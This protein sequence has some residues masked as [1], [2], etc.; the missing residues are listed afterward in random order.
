MLNIKLE[1][2]ILFYEKMDE[3]VP[4]V[5]KELI[6]R[7][8]RNLSEYKSKG[9]NEAQ[10][11]QEY[12]N[13]FFKAL[14]W[15]VDN[16]SGA[17]PAYRDV[18]HEDS[19]KIK[20]GTK[21]PDYCF[22]LSGRKMFFVEAKKP[23]INIINDSNPSYQLRR[24]AWSAKLSLSI[25]TNFEE[26]CIYE[27]RQKPHISDKSNVERV[28]HIKY[29]EYIDRWDEIESV[30]SYNSVKQGSFDHFAKSVKK[31]RGTQEVG[32][33]F[34]KEI[35]D[36]RDKLAKNIAI[37]NTKIGV[38]ELNFCVQKTIDR[39]IFLRM[40]EDRGIESY[41]QLRSIAEKQNIY[42]NLS[43]IFKIADKKYNSGLFHFHK[44]KNRT[45]LPDE[46]TLSLKIDDKILKTIFRH[47]Y[48]PNSPYEFSVLPPEIL[49][50]VYEQFLGKI[51]RLTE[52]H[53]AKIEEKPEVK[54]A[55][56]VF[57]TP[58][59]IVDYIVQ[60]TLKKICDGKTPK[61]ISKIKILDP[62][63]GSG[64]F[65]L[66]A[67]TYLLQYHLDYYSKQK[68]NKR[69]KNE[70]FQ[71]KDGQLFLTIKEKKR[72]L[73]NNIYGVDIDNQA[74]EVT[75]L[76]LLLKVLEGA[77]KD[78]FE[79]Q[80]KLWIERALPDLDGNIKCGNSLIGPDFYTNLQTTLIDNDEIININAFDWHNEF[81]EIMENGGFDLVIG[82]PPYRMLQP[83]NTTND[84][85]DYLRNNFFA[86]DFKIDFFHLF[87]Q[88]GISLLKKRN[89]HLGFIVP[90]TLLNNVY[91]QNLRQ[92]ITDRCCID[93][94]SVANDKV[95]TAD[96]FTSVVIL[97]TEPDKEKRENNN[98]FT[99][100]E[101]N[102]KF[103]NQNYKPESKTKQKDLLKLQGNV[104][105]ILINNKNSKIIFKIIKNNRP[106]G[107][108]AQINR[109]LIT[110]NRDKYF[111]KSK[112]T[113][114]H[115]P[116]IAGADVFRYYNNPPSEFVLFERPS[117]AGGCWDKE[118]HNA[119]HKLIIR[120]IGKR[121][122]ASLLNQPLAV[123]GNIFTIQCNDLEKE[124][125]ILGI[126]N[127][128][129]IYFFWKIMF[130]DFK[131]S[132]PQVTIFSLSQIPIY[133][134][135]PNNKKENTLNNKI[136]KSV[137]HMLE[138]HRLINRTKI[139]NECKIIQRQI[140][141]IENQINQLVYELYGLN[142]KEIEII[143]KSI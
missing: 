32:G 10:L 59:Y 27:S 94:I 13:P 63:C 54:K 142:K 91:I 51:I 129:L 89:A 20:G 45:T 123:T 112:D 24:Y 19:I 2:V 50:N 18:I 87:F 5:I 85:L 107:E 40:C 120:Q 121:P 117:T 33:E 41:G 39:I 111:S 15:D 133:E 68:N 46:W 139:E 105:N 37:R 101:L 12:I 96:V 110:G 4:K 84:I 141:V 132:F 35:E 99:T 58:A 73:L 26:L 125:L 113:S 11:R 128:K 104:W 30:F 17:A 34:L 124:K 140:D 47:L 43:K 116:I 82:N 16:E 52:S 7:F 109:G 23:S 90:V 57:Y 55:G 93:N 131:A 135:D 122:T 49:G 100:T 60:N 79:Q 92:W 14:G 9:Y 81:K 36:W 25:L 102:E 28:K 42:E 29:T 74:V 38:R 70:V 134:I 21:A 6:E 138:L 56:G 83:H 77:S 118:M 108:I 67:Y 88:R 106:L 137:D 64:S 86:A 127:S 80:Q 115:M 31:K 98:I 62:A 119:P 76:S 53:H 1:F 66:G 65:L 61:Q 48:Y 72:I 126:T 78:I 95:F 130:T 136:V 8:Q 143:E 75:K 3:K 103:V 44:E 22:T 69:Y 114:S 71:S 97:R